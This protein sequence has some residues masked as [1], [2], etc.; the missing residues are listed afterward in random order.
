MS[1]PTHVHTCRPDDMH[2]EIWDEH[3]WE[4]SSPYCSRV[5]RVCP[6]HGGEKV[7]IE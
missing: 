3:T 1:D 2:I 4:C 5:I 7:R 6:K